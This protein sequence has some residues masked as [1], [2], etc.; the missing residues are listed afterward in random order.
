MVT[1]VFSIQ[2]FN[3]VGCKVWVVINLHI[4]SLEK[5]VI[6]KYIAP[7]SLIDWIKHTQKSFKGGTIFQ[8]EIIK[9]F[10]L[11]EDHLAWNVGDGTSVRIGLD[12]WPGS[13]LQHLLPQNIRGHLAKQGILHLN[14]VTDPRGTTIWR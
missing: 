3:I 8:K 2:I 6:Q 12:P 4:Q 13:G 5:V 7:S 10:H 14:Q 1:I 11:I 9:S